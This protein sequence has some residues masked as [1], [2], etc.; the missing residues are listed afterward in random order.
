MTRTFIRGGWRAAFG[1]LLIATLAACGG[2]SDT[3]VDVTG[4]TACEGSDGGGGPVPVASDIDLRLSAISLPNDGSQTALLTVTALNANRN[5]IPAVPVT[6]SVDNGGIVTPS[7]TVTDD[8]GQ[9]TAAVG[10]GSNGSNRVMTVT[11]TSGSITRTAAIEVRDAV[12]GGTDGPTVNLALSSTNVTPTTPATVTVTVRSA[13]GTPLS[14]LVVGLTTSRGNLATLAAPSVLTNAQGIATTTLQAATGGLSGADSLAAVANLGTTTVNGSVGFTVSGAAPTLSMAIANTTL[15][16]SG[17]PV[18]LT[19]T[20]RDAQGQPVSGQVVNFSSTAGRVVFAQLAALTNSAGVAQTTAL[21][22]DGTVSAADAIQ[23]SSSVG[24]Q[25]LNSSLGV[26]IIGESH[27]VDA[28][29]TPNNQVTLTQPRTVQV[30]VRNAQNA[31]IPNQVVS[32]SSQFNLVSFESPTVITG[33]NGVATVNVSPRTA[34][35]SGA[36]VVVASV[37]IGSVTR[38]RQVVAQVTSSTPAG[39][40]VLQMTLSSTSISAASPATV[41]ATLT[42]STGSPVPGQVV[43]FAVVRGLASSNVPTALTDEFG[44][45]VVVLA[46]ASATSAGADEITASASYAGAALQ[47]TAG[48]QVQATNVTINSFTAT[49]LGGSPLSAYGQTPLTITLTGASPTSPV[50]ITVSSACVAQGKASLSPSKF[51]ATASPVTLQYRDNGC[52]AVQTQD[53]LQAVIDGTAVTSSL[54]IRIDPPM[55]TSLAFVSASPEV[56]FL[57]GSGFTES[58]IVTFEVRDAAGNQLPGKVVELRLLTGAGGVTMEGRPVES[59]N[60]PSPNPFTQ[61][62][63]ALG[64]VSVRVNSGTLP[65]PVRVHAKIQDTAIAT[66]SSNLSVAVG[67]PSQLNFSLS[68]GTRNIEGYNIDGTPNTYQI[69]AADR[70]GNPAPAGTSINFVTEG[71]QVEAIKQIQSVS[72]LARATANFVSAEPRPVDGRVTVVAYTLGEESFLDANGN[73]SYDSGES[74]QDL[75]NVFKDRNFDG[76]FS[77][78]VDE[79]IPLSINNDSTCAAPGNPLLRL[80]AS[81]PSVVDTCDTRWSGAGQVY[82]RRA[83]ETVLSTSAA[84]PLWANVSGLLASSCQKLTMQIGPDPSDLA[85]FTVVGADTWYGNGP[86]GTLSFI[87]GDAN[88]GSAAL[89]L[90][91]RLNPMA[92]GT[93]ISAT[94]PTDGLNVTVGGGTPVPSTTEASTAAVAYSFDT[95]TSGV[96]FITFR[97]PSG[98]GTTFAVNVSVDA[99]PTAVCTPDP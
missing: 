92:A 69:I 12:I 18:S 17:G 89:G 88:P 50:N 79:F 96:I 68:Q 81:I 20:L 83:T 1:A 90:S 7:G 49:A 36:D 54:S 93:T 63:N 27:S 5:A 76:L 38:T 51:S 34:T 99:P 67:L 82:V 19:A 74:F 6:V 28:V 30:T 26:Q 62:S 25:A 29:L 10:I 56:I 80:D 91:P 21:P 97:S 4:G 9:L 75:G 70:S 77:F 42:D 43:T 78:N 44:R 55:E 37:T 65:T 85:Q 53:Q 64:Q 33:T 98:T 11:A 87:V 2:G 45:A 13:T 52:G 46:P 94:T 16:A 15:T 48:F 59:I 86:S 61:T 66:V 60:P 31:P 24:S 73:N 35:S 47:A 95:A 57:K 39:N 40:P 23:A 14:G 58:S 72:G 84:R 41:T 8:Q 3:C 71:G 32:L 22:A